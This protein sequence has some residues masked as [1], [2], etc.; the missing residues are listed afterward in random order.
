MNISMHAERD[1]SSPFA[2]HR[3]ALLEFIPRRE[4]GRKLKGGGG[5]KKS[6]SNGWWWWEE[7]GRFRRLSYPSQGTGQQGWEVPSA[8]GATGRLPRAR[9]AS[10]WTWGGR[11]RQ[12]WGWCPRWRAAAGPRNQPGPGLWVVDW[13][14]HSEGERE[15]MNYDERG[16]RACWSVGYMKYFESCSHTIP[17]IRPFSDLNSGKC[18]DNRVRT[19]SLVYVWKHPKSE[20]HWSRRIIFLNFFTYRDQNIHSFDTCWYRMQ[21]IL[22]YFKLNRNIQIYSVYS[23][24]SFFLDVRRLSLRSGITSSCQDP[25]LHCRSVSLLVMRLLHVVSLSFSE[26]SVLVWRGHSKLSKL[27]FGFRQISR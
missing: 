12:T 25:L 21:T 23:A 27:S 26:C 6:G 16:H 18:T 22:M 15:E 11:A 2:S 19:F 24:L 14:S 13:H 17:E 5:V 1:F 8:Q 20:K 3:E 10:H 9:A 7:R 4:E